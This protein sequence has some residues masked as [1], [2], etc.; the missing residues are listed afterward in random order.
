MRKLLLL[1][2]LRQCRA[3]LSTQLHHHPH[4]ITHLLLRHSTCAR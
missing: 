2:M 4:R 3:A 1:E